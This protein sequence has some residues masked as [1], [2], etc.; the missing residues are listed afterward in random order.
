MKFL[1]IE[2]DSKAFIMSV[3]SFGIEMNKDDR[4]KLCLQFGQLALNGRCRITTLKYSNVLRS[5]DELTFFNV[6]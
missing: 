6:Y 5:F 3:N 1:A 4:A 2:A